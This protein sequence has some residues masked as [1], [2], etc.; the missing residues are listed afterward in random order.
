[1]LGNHKL[2]ALII[3]SS[4]LLPTSSSAK[5]YKCVD[6][7]GKTKFQDK[8]CLDSDKTMSTAE[9]EKK[10]LKAP[11]KSN[12]KVTKE[13]CEQATEQVYKFLLKDLLPMLSIEEKY[14]AV[15]LAVNECLADKTPGKYNNLQCII[16]SNSVEEMKMCKA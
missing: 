4:A 7:T 2:L 3:I 11:N 16:E 1:M 6:P 13:M 8:P 12:S 10:Q 9:L 15:D 14:K 5:I